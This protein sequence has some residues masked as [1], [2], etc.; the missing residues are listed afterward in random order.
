MN[1]GVRIEREGAL[2]LL[3]FDRP[4]K[5]NAVTGAMYG[6][7]AAA[8]EEADGDDGI[9]VCVFLGAPGMFSAGNDI[10]DFVA[11]AAQGRGLGEPILRFLRA[12]AGSD[13]PLMAGVDGP[14]V[15]IGTTLLLHCDYVLATPR[16]LF[17]TPF[18]A[19]G[20]VPEAASSLL[21]PRLIGHARAFELLVM[22]GDLD[23]ETARIC[24]LVN[25][26]VEPEEL[27]A[28]LLGAARGL[29]AKPRD[30]VLASRR[31][32]KGEPAEALARI[33]AEAELF[34]ERLRSP[35]AQAA[36]AAFLEK[37]KR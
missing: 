3:R 31:L 16:S 25:R 24:G 36:F 13:R 21:A 12:L 26:V 35:E 29:A 17:R 34:A 1:A 9:G 18:A 4:D 20:L 2:L 14:A 5:K 8:L 28:E 27:E 37:G 7:L 22:G 10:A 23:A 15:G 19:L 11:M 30:A 32:L 33:D 6:A